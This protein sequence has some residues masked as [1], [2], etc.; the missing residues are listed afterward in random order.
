MLKS[1]I[2]SRRDRSNS[3]RARSDLS[4]ASNQDSGS[5]RK[6][7]S[8]KSYQVLQ[9][10]LEQSLRRRSHMGIRGLFTSSLPRVSPIQPEEKSFKSR[11]KF[12]ARS[13]AL[14]SRESVVNKS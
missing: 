7:Y 1:S 2:K 5:E 9:G 11:I 10:T 3:T 13:V 12:S 8:K 6:S 4:R 14:Y